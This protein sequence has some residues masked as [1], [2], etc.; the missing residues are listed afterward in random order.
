MTS[1]EET[2]AE[3][4]RKRL[5]AWKRRRQQAAPA[6]AAAAPPP[7][8]PPMKV[9]LSLNVSSKQPTRKKKIVP[10]PP[11]PK[12]INPFGSVDDDEEDEDSE[13]EGKKTNLS[14]GLGFSLKDEVDERAEE[15][16]PIKRRKGRWD[17]GPGEQLNLTENSAGKEKSQRSAECSTSIGDTL[18]KFMDKLQA[19]ALGS[20]VTQVSE[21]SGTEMLS[22][23]VGGSMMR[24]PKLKQAQP[25]PVSGGVIT[26]EQLA[27]MSATISSAKNSKDPEALYAPS[28]WE[29]DD[30]RGGASEVS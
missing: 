11:P 9:S 18:E 22:I 25:S 8:P 29:S 12:P 5:E 15:Q 4:K 28:D 27:K 10:P 1:E 17:S 26:P 3:R 20:V 21:A 19:G 6:A 13:D 2:A 7:P 23:D 24:V 14:L 16:R 30:H